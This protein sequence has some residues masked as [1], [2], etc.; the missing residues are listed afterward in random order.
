MLRFIRNGNGASNTG[1]RVSDGT[2]NLPNATL[3]QKSA[4]IKD[5]GKGGAK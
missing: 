2:I 1:G 4:S 3:H 5:I